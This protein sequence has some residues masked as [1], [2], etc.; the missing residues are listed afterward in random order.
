VVAG[1]VVGAAGELHPRLAREL[2]FPQAPLLFELNLNALLQG[3]IPRAFSISRFPHV[4]RD[5]AVTVPLETTYG[6]LRDRVSVAGGPLLRDLHAFDVY[7][8][9]GIESGRKSIAL[10]LI[11]QDNNR[12]LTDDEA[13]AL[14]ARIAADL[15]AN[16]GAKL[17]D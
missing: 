11:F 13:D 7:Q 14:M 9:P 6:A 8:G 5:L 10:G 12:T 17:R 16:L 15:Q 1:Q 3:S 2:D 4:R